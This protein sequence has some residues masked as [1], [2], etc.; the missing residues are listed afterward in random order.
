VINWD[1][2][3][4]VLVKSIK[5]KIAYSYKF[6][7][8]NKKIDQYCRVKNMVHTLFLMMDG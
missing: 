3:F 1:S 2:L 6:W 4:P 5:F 7:W 8:I